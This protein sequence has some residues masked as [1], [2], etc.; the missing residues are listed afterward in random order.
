MAWNISCYDYLNN[1]VKQVKD[2]LSEKD[3]SLKH[4]GTGLSPYPASYRPEVAVTE[5]LDEERTNRF[6]QLIGILGWAI[7]LGRIHILTEVSPNTWL[8]REK[9]ILLPSTRYLNI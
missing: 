2:E 3:L 4:F 5:V 1:A 7:E 6:Q 9:G 8:S